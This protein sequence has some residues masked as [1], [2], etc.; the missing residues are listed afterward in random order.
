MNIDEVKKELTENMVEA[1]LDYMEDPM[2]GENLEGYASGCKYAI[3]LLEN[4]QEKKV[5]IPQFVADWITRAKLECDYE[6]IYMT[7]FLADSIDEGTDYHFDWLENIENQKVLLNAITNG[8]EVEEDRKRRY[9][10]RV[11][12]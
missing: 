11:G 6:P 7:E 1:H 4:L 2:D 8:Y 5:I 12:D 3:E 9:Q 10:Q